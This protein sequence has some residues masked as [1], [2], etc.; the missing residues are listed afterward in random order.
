MTG[1]PAPSAHTLPAAAGHTHDEGDWTNITPADNVQHWGSANA[2]VRLINGGT[3]VE[4]SGR[5]ELTGSVSSGTA[6][7]T[8]PVGHRPHVE[9]KL[10]SRSAG[11]GATGNTI[12][13]G[14]DGVITF[15]A[16][17]NSGAML[18]MDSVTFRP[19]ST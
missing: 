13:V 2:Q 8:L 7:G 9:L 11:T 14:T 16:S 10:S 19:A 4:A 6:W 12:T 1:R 18:P 5:L 3:T 17:L 15:G